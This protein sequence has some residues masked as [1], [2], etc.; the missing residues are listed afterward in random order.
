M[1]CIFYYII[2]GLNTSKGP[3]WNVSNN[4]MFREDSH[5]VQIHVMETHV[6]YLQSYLSLLSDLISTIVH[7][8]I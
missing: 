2:L 1:I 6:S 4:A 8:Y 7:V 3:D 5:H